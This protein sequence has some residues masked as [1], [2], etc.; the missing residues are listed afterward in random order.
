[1]TIAQIKEQLGLA[2]IIRHYGLKAD[3]HGRLRCPFHDDRTPSLQLYYKTQTAYCFSTG[4]RTHGRSMD[5]IDFIMHYEKCTKGEAIRKA[6]QLTGAGP[7]PPPSPAPGAAGERTMFLDRMFTYFKNAVHNSKPAR[8][9]LAS[10]CIDFRKTEAGYNAGQFHHGTRKDETLIGQCLQYGLLMELGAKARTGEA[11]YK[12][13]GKWC[14]VF[15]LRNPVHEITGLYF[16]S[17][18]NDKDQRHFYLRDRSGLYPG[19]PDRAARRLI[20]TE[21]IIDAATLLE[22]EPIKSRYAVLSLYG[23]N[24][25]TEE[26][27]T[28]IRGLEQ[29]EELIFFLNGDEAGQ[30]AVSKYGAVLR[31]GRP[32]LKITVVAVPQDEDVNSLVQGHSPEILTHLLD[33]RKE[34]DFIL[35]TDAAAG[36]EKPAVLPAAATAAVPSSPPEALPGLDTQNPYNLKYRGRAALY[37]VRGFRAEQPDSLRVTLQVIVQQPEH[38]PI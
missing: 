30:A 31:S 32:K 37:Q 21:S 38:M 14:I 33:T 16:R 22:Q 19:Y 6:E 17:T 23:A 34:L 27:G 20:L 7:V 13:F 18:I 29:L 9:Y 5:V 8:D 2:D 11:A 1:M 35:S 28:A 15:A 36:T 26:H 24:G 10:R 3:K 25:F 12:P 4:C